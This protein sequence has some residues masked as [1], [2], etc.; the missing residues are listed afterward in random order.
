[1]ITLELNNKTYKSSTLS[2]IG[3][4]GYSTPV[5]KRDRQDPARSAAEEPCS[6]RKQS[7][8][9]KESNLERKSSSSWSTTTIHKDSL[10][11]L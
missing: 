8:S 9:D 2:R 1:V 4:E 5:R 3:V 11:H 10:A 7:G 6:A